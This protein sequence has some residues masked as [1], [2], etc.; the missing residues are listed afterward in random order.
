MAGPRKPGRRQRGALH[1]S[2]GSPPTPGRVDPA[3]SSVVF[4]LLDIYLAIQLEEALG[5]R[6]TAPPR[7]PFFL[8][9]AALLLLLAGEVVPAGPALVSPRTRRLRDRGAG[10][11]PA[12]HHLRGVGGRGP[13]LGTGEPLGAI[14][15]R[16][17]KAGKAVESLAVLQ[18]QGERGS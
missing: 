1:G 4:Y 15:G 16:G 13:W 18:R 11:G 10:G 3:P 7:R 5:A 6:P 8:L 14:L 17:A 9:P 12:R 2:A